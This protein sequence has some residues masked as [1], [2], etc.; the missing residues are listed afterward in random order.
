MAEIIEL[1]D[2]ITERMDDG[3][4]LDEVEAELIESRADLDDEE[5]A[6]LWLFAWSSVPLARHRSVA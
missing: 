1:R 6:A 3:A 2:A 4:S 5:K